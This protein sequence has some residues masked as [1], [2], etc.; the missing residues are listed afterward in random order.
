MTIKLPPSASTPTVSAVVGSSP[1]MVDDVSFNA[2]PSATD[3]ANAVPVLPA[4]APALAWV[5]I[6]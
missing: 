2:M 5:A 6:A 3:P 4:L 1:T